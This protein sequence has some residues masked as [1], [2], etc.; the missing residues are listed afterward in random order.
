MPRP[1]SLRGLSTKDERK[2]GRSRLR[3]ALPNE[4]IVPERT[5]RSSISAR[6]VCSPSVHGLA[7]GS[8]VCIRY[9]RPSQ[10]SDGYDTPAQTNLPPLRR[11]HA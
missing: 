4:P 7:P 5:F 2:A 6:V 3:Y 8:G 9:S 11:T 10:T 1:A